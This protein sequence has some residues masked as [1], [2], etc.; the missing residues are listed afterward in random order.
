MPRPAPPVARGQPAGRG[1]APAERTTLLVT[2]SFVYDRYLAYGVDSRQSGE[3]RGAAA[4]YGELF[5][6]PFLELSNGRPAFA[7]F[8]PVLRIVALDDDAEHLRSLAA[9]LHRE[10]SNVTVTL[11]DPDPSK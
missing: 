5:T 4:H 7:F 6:H 11:V 2:S 10:H 1:R 9:K 3:I 8:N